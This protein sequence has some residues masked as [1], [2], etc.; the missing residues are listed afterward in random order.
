MAL[1]LL[2]PHA[3]GGRAARLAPRVKAWL[4]AHAPDAEFAAPASLDAS[5]SLLSQQSSGARVV[6]IGGDGTLNRWLPVLLHKQIEL[7]LVPFGSGNDT[8]RAIGTYGQ[9]WT[10]A[11]QQAL[12]ASC[13]PMDVGIALFNGQQTP[14]LSSF[15]AGFDSAVGKRALDGPKWLRGLPRYVWATLN[16]LA[17]IQTWDLQISINGELRFDGAS[18]FASSLNT[19]T[20]GSGMPAAP[21]GHIADGCLDV[22]H[23]REFRAVEALWM[24]PRLLTGTHLSHPKIAMWPAQTIHIESKQPLPVASDGEYLGT[25]HRLELQV[26]PKALNV[27]MNVS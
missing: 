13:A 11:L 23:A 24:L 14:F 19:P 25:T 1:V 2:N 7:G 18:L 17:H 6:A 20:F 27:V 12:S 3:Q 10:S 16:E 9:H 15:T 4:M 22:L 8:A 5:L 26:S 21:Q